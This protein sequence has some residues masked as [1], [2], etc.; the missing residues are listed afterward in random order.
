[1]G[2]WGAGIM[3]DDTVLD[4][5]DEFKD[6]LKE[7]QNIKEA[8]ATLIINNNYLIEDEDQGPLFWI[9]L[10]K[11][12]WE[13]GELESEVYNHVVKDFNQ[14]SGL[15]LWKEGSGKEYLKRKRVI[16]DFILKISKPNVKTKKLPKKVI[17]KPIFQAGDCLSLKVND[18]YY[19]AALVVRYDDSNEEYG[20]NLIIA[21]DYWEK[22][23]P[24]IEDFSRTEFL[25]LTIGNWNGRILDAWCSSFGFKGLKNK[26]V[27]V[28]NID[29]SRFKELDT[30]YYFRW[31]SFLRQI[32]M[33]KSEN[34]M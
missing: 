29:V 12:Q 26:I 10:A 16:S 15:S 33:Q 22:R 6:L 31:D 20:K 8:T 25:A 1:M 11:C 7:N 21:L 19:G 27:N 5:I 23:E 13:Y 14:E 4:I 28:G 24:V 3:Q 17:R 2:A 18:E 30:T 9:A 34:T 32:E